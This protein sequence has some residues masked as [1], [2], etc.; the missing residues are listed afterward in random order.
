M[1]G[2]N[3]ANLLPTGRYRR[4]VW[5]V[6]GLVLPAGFLAPECHPSVS[7][8]SPI[9]C[10]PLA[11]AESTWHF[12]PLAK[13]AALCPGRR[14][15]FNAR[16]SA[17][18]G[19]SMLGKPGWL[20]SSPLRDASTHSICFCAILVLV[21]P[22]PAPRSLGALLPDPMYPGVLCPR[23]RNPS[24]SSCHL[25]IF[26]CAKA[27]VTYKFYFKNNIKNKKERQ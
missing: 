15:G 25:F 18:Q 21:T 14:P 2:Q 19:P 26:S 22:L 5:G 13:P 4:P 9:Q 10:L 17:S 20:V 24:L 8:S 7:L 16:S 6:E 12:L 3:P 1:R 27:H 23:T 11:T